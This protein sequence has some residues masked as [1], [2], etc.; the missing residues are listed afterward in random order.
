MQKLG[1]NRGGYHG[2]RIEIATLLRDIAARATKS[3]W[4]PDPIATMP[5]VELGAWHRP[6]GES[7]RQIYISSGIHGDE[8]AG[9]L[10]VQRLLLEDNWPG[11]VGLTLCPC[12]NPTGFPLNRR[13]NARG[14]DLNRQYLHLEA[15]ETRAHVEWLQRQPA[16]DVAICLHEDWESQGFYL[17]ELNPD[18]R[19]SHAE[20]II[21]EVA[22]VCPID[23]SPEIE[24]RPAQNGIIR[25][26]ADPLT[27]AQW[28]EAFWLL[29][30]KTRHSY[31]MEAPSDFPLETRVR[32]LVTAVKVVLAG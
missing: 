17:Y 26:S 27:R 22:A 19:P 9:P 30:H 8:P 13:E 25:P 15:E 21:R 2:E 20:K 6:N 28:P 11:D 7:R 4:T 24:G 3:G 14:I 12:L 5:A 29:K 32:A 18:Q 16:F 1:K 31:T 10:A 23:S